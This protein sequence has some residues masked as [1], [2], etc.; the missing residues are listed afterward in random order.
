M[1]AIVEIRTD[2]VSLVSDTRVSL[3]VMVC[4]HERSGTHFLINSI[5]DNSL[6]SNEPFLRFDQVPLGSFLNFHDAREVRAFFERLAK[7]SCASVIKNHFAAGFFIDKKGRFILEGLCKTIY[8]VRNPIDVM[9]SYHRFIDY[10]S[11]HEG[12]KKKHTFDFLSTAPEGQMLR[13][14]NSQ[15][16]TIL[17][18]WKSHVLGWLKLTE[19]NSSN[20]LLVKYRDLDESHADTTRKVLSFLGLDHQ[21]AI[22]RPGRMLKTIHIP[23]WRGTPFEERERIREYV[24]KWIDRTDAI[25]DLF[26]EIHEQLNA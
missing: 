15:I 19:E 9:L 10:F 22:V 6:Y 20:V 23:D 11:W 24:C 4:S 3:P 1:R 13:Y 8:I 14:Q 16:D 21:E 26:P 5:A 12:P 2:P 25:K 17:E 7:Y 18:R